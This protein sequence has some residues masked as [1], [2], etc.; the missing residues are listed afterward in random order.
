MTTETVAPPRRRLPL[1]SGLRR[2]QVGLLERVAL[3][4]V[5]VLT[6][7]LL[8]VP[9]VLPHTARDIVGDPFV[10][11]GGHFWLGTDSQ[12][13]D[14]FSRVLLGL[15][16]SWF[17]ALAVIVL[18]ALV[19]G[20]IGL[21]AGIAG[22][23]V[24]TVLMRLTDAALAL[25][26]TLVALMVVAALGPSLRNTLLAVAV[27]WWPWYARI[28]RGQTRTVMQLPHVDAARLGGFSAVRRALVHVLPGSLGPVLV[29][30]SLDIGSVLLVLAGL[31]FIGL[32]S[33]APAAEIGSMSAN[34][35][36]Y[37]FNAPWIALAPAV[38]LFAV[39]VLAN[40][41]G[42]GLQELADA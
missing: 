24:D 35:L 26:G 12:G 36:T 39:A 38:A 33:P 22:G 15:R 32:G 18:G 10:A 31:S 40:F 16:T 29:A 30:A 3:V 23:V 17:G 37:L 41:A 11:P 42:D 13:R 9:A 1:L 25:P 5:V 19:G 20:T 7:L 27:T 28:V 6:L 34:G 2:T 21:V 14:V 8:A 4:A